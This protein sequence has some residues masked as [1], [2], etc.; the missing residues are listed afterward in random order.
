[1][2]ENSG[3]GGFE[4]S[5]KKIF[6]P[7]FCAERAKTAWGKPGTVAARGRVNLLADKHK[8]SIFIRMLAD[9]FGQ[10]LRLGVAEF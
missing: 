1:M 3:Q 9:V 5:S 10:L 2:A 4:Q 6:T 7:G 8:L